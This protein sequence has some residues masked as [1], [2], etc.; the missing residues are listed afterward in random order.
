[1][2]FFFVR[3]CSAEENHMDVEALVRA[4]E[5]GELPN[6]GFH[7]RDHVRV[8]WWYLCRY[9]LPGALGR[10]RLALRRFAEARGAPE[11]YHETITT[12]Y[13]LLINERLDET[14][15]GSWEEFAARHADL[16]SWEPSIL[17]RYYRDETLRSDRARRVFVMPDRLDV[18]ADGSVDSQ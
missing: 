6:G 8:A 2:P 18:V 5:A 3:D 4:F 11:R 15:R 17:A 9:S 12:A 13:V 10:F 1:V 16:L 7:H 14:G